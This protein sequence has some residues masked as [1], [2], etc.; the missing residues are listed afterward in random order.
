MPTMP[1]SIAMRA[2]SRARPAQRSSERKYGMASRQMVVERRGKTGHR[3]P[4]CWWIGADRGEL[5]PPSQPPDANL[6]IPMTRA[7]GRRTRG[8]RAVPRRRTGI[9]L[10]LRRAAAGI[11]RSSAATRRL[12]RLGRHPVVAPASRQCHFSGSDDRAL[13][14]PAQLVL[15]LML[16]V[17]HRAPRLGPPLIPLDPAALGPPSIFSIRLLGR[18]SV[19]LRLM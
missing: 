19:Q 4:L 17:H 15:G 8:R 1:S 2:A 10:M 7:S 13:A 9:G 16:A 14:R 11:H 3:W 12:R 6:E 5:W 18:M